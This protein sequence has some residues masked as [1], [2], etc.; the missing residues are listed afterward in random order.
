MRTWPRV[1]FGRSAAVMLASTAAFVLLSGGAARAGEAAGDVR[2]ELSALRAEVAALRAELEAIKASLNS[3]PRVI[4]A[5]HIGPAIAQTNA[6]GQAPDAQPDPNAIV[7]LLQTQVAELAQTKV[8]TE[9]RMPLRL[10]GTIH[11]HVFANSGTPN[12]LDNPNLLNPAPPEGS[13]GTFTAALRQTRIGLVADGPT[14]GSFRS[15]A[16]LALDFLGGMPGF[17]TGQVMGLP[18]ILVAFARLENDRTAFV[19]GQ[20]HVMLAPRDPTSLAAFAFPLLFRSGNLYL[21]APQVRVEQSLSAFARLQGGIVA[22]IGGDVPGEDYRFVPPALAGERSRRPG[23]QVRLALSAPH[24]DEQRMGEI[25]LSGHYGWERR[26]AD[27]VTSWAAAVDFGARRDRIG[28]AGELYVGDNADA[29]GGALGLDARTAGGWA[30]IQLFPSERLTLAAG[31][32]LDRLRRA[33][34]SPVPRRRN[35]TAFSTVIF[36]L[37]PELQTSFEYRWLGLAPGEGSE[38]RNHH[39]DWVFA[40]RF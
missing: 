9:S 3:T 14:L 7:D 10:F 17:Q 37:T 11:S 15:S 19:F 30:E 28:V 38:R 31:G 26:G 8:G 32:G 35:R 29:F 39:F 18:R 12:W 4:A 2:A 1:R 24:G 25:G 13:E 34:V 40:Y 23:L 16:N 6:A 21:R 22:P 20:D 33:R 27:L 36:S 5:A